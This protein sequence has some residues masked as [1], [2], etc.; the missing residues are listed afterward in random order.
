MNEGGLQ[1]QASLSE[2]TTMRGT[3]REGSLTGDP[4]RNDRDISRET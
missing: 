4:E 2:G 1:E 3:W